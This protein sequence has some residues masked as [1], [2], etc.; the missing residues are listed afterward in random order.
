MGHSMRVER[1]DVD[2]V[3]DRLAQLKRKVS[4]I[5]QESVKRPSALEELEKKMEMEAERKEQNKKRKKEELV[6]KKTEKV[7]EAEEDDNEAELQA[8]LGFSGFKSSKK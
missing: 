1:A 8:M 7:D 6:A 4:N 5:S 3:K 2:T